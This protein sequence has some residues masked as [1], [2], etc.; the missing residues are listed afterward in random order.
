MTHYSTV[1]TARYHACVCCV[2]AIAS[3]SLYVISLKVEG[4]VHCD[5]HSSYTQASLLWKALPQ[6]V[7]GWDMSPGS[8]YFPTRVFPGAME[9]RRGSL[10]LCRTSGLD[11]IAFWFFPAQ[12][13][14]DL[15]EHEVTLP[16][17][18][19]CSLLLHLNFILSSILEDALGI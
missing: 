4:K 10:L 11:L 8:F 16:G 1:H 6:I 17:D 2:L 12:I 7:C 19:I 13:F 3:A 18:R 9:S 14:D 15:S 5:H